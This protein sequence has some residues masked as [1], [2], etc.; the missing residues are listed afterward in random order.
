M[1]TFK[2]FLF[3]TCLSPLALSFWIP[4]LMT[5]FYFASRGMA[6]FGNSSILTVDLGQQYIDQ[7]ALFKNTVMNHPGSFFY[8]FSSG[9]GGDMI[10]EF[11]YYLMSPLNFI[12]LF[13]PNLLLP[14]GIL[15][16]LVLKFGLAG[17]TMA[18]LIK[19]LDLQRGYY[20]T[21]FAINYPL[22]GWFVANNLNL[23]WLDTAIL[24]PLV[25]W[26]L[27]RLITQNKPLPYRLLLGLTILSNYYIAFMVA[28]FIGL[29]FIWRLL[30]LTQKR[31]QT[32]LQFAWSSLIG[33]LL[34]AVVVLPAYY[35][36][37]LGKTQYNTPWTWRF[38]NNPLDL[39]VKLIPGSFNFDQMQTGLANIFVAFLILLAVVAFF[40]AKNFSWRVKIGAGLILAILIL[41][42]TWAP[43]TLIFHGGQYPVWYPYRFSFILVFFAI[44]LGALGFKPNWQPHAITLLAVFTGIIAIAIFASL[45]VKT[46]PFLNRDLILL[47]M[48]LSAATLA[49]FI[50]PMPAKLR[51]AVL[52]LITIMSLN[53]NLS[54]SLNNFSYINNDEYQRTVQSL[55]DGVDII[56]SDTSW[57]RVAQTFQ[58][59][60]GDSMMADFYGGSHFSSLLPKNTTEFFAKIGQPEGDNYVVYS[61][62]TQWTDDW[63]GCKY[64]L[65]ANPNQ[66]HLPGAPTSHLIGYRPDVSSDQLVGQS[67]TVKVYENPNALPVGFA[68]SN[69][70][71]KTQLFDDSPMQ[72]QDQI[73]QKLTGE[74]TNLISATNFD[75]AQGHNLNTPITVTD[76]TV[77]RI[78][79]SQPASLDLTFTPTT[80]DPYYLTIGGNLKIDQFD[81]LINGHVVPQFSSYRH[82]IVVNLA[83]R[84]KNQPQTLTLRLRDTQSLNLS[85]VALYHLNE[86][87]LNQGVNQLKAHTWQIKER[88]ERR[89]SGT[90]TTTKEQSLIMTTIPSV[91]G[92]KAR[93]DGKV[94]K[95]KLA[96]GYFLAI[97]AKPGQ[98]QLT[99]SYTPPLFWPGLAATSLGLVICATGWGYRRAQRAKSLQEG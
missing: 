46:F 34:S 42:T 7:F 57:Y 93:L 58:R 38:D 9:L 44:Y 94:V 39:L 65:T 80:D 53:T 75:S 40:V 48:F 36:L 25:V 27:E 18:F 99:L 74:S 3:K 32:T 72:N 84:A 6:P 91:P 13:V 98:H 11:A 10:G 63:L 77:T 64:L 60:R 45:Q 24:L 31:W 92:W 20:I 4:V 61:N 69:Q 33:G 73:F 14:V 79:P 97:P 16:V 26:A 70:I 95:T 12:F 21:L 35:Q 96:A 5:L 76:A 87:V 67:D 89:L 15:F 49:C 19:K 43:L 23:L 68:A 86:N 81:I 88:S 17:L 71:L 83:N 1:L 66:P 51:L 41:A 59:T 28:L 85:N 30:S 56:D 78:D 29:Y 52:S 55:T 50:G 62:G 2:K 22:C 37:G 90:V 8:S 47:F 54:A 82:T